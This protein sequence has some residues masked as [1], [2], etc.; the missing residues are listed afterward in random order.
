MSAFAAALKLLYIRRPFFY[1][2]HLV[3]ALHFQSFLFMTLV[4]VRLVNIAAD[5]VGLERF[6]PGLAM[7]IL[8]V[9]V[10]APIYLLLALRRVYGADIGADEVDP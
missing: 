6:V 9:L 5:P 10:V 1:V 3:F 4:L 7:S 2:D 8:I